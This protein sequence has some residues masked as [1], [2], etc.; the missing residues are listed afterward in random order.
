MPCRSSL[1]TLYPLTHAR[2]ITSSAA[3]FRMSAPMDLTYTP[4]RQAELRENIESVQAEIDA[5]AGPSSKVSQKAS[6]L[7]SCGRS[8]WKESLMFCSGPS[9]RHLQAQA[10]IGHQGAVR[11]WAPSFRGELH[12]GDGRQGRSG[13]RVDIKTRLTWQLPKDIHWH[14]VGSLQSNKSKLAACR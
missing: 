7:L 5:V 8:R 2:R 6:N 14:F 3:L 1:R 13:E 4:D 9:R 10:G 11:C 12:P